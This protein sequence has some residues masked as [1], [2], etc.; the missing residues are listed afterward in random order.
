MEG[1]AMEDGDGDIG[2]ATPAV[3]L[4]LSQLLSLSPVSLIGDQDTE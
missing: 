3:L 4:E 2:L 1:M